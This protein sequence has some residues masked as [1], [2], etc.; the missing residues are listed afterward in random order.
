MHMIMKAEVYKDGKWQPVGK[1]FQSALE[2][3][4]LTDRVCDERNPILY[5]I[6]GGPKINGMISPIEGIQNT[7]EGYVVYLSDILNYNWDDTIC[8]NGLISEWQYRRYKEQGIKPAYVRKKISDI[9]NTAVV[10]LF[11]MDD[12]LENDDLRTSQKYY[13]NYQYDFK[14]LHELCCFFHKTSVA[15][16]VDLAT[17]NKIDTVR[18]IYCFK[19]VD[20]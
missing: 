1:I 10:S 15:S 4:M 7:D 8:S 6:F 17:D 9:E 20:F 11:E 2:E 14:S 18:V 3:N 19:G 5:E 12:I 16:L 13:V